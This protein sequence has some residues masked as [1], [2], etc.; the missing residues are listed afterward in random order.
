MKQHNN[1]V[2]KNPGFDIFQLVDVGLYLWMAYC[3]LKLWV[4]PTAEDVDRIYF[5]SIL[6]AF[7]FIMVHS[8]V[9]MAA[10]PLK[11]SLLLF[12]PVYGL[13]AFAFNLFVSDNSILYLYLGVVL[14][15]MRF[16]FFNKSKQ[17]TDQAIG[18][19]AYAVMVYFIP[20]IIVAIFSEKVPEFGVSPEFLEQAGYK[21][22]IGGIFTEM[23]QTALCLG[24][25]YYIL[26]AL[27]PIL[28]FVNSFKAWMKKI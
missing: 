9:F 27:L 6:I 2:G 18:F 24:A 19:S 5:M 25:C 22:K 28:M 11:W 3:F 12:F 23:P 13:F 17:A 14:F 20:M 4:M 21:I 15:R 16:A 10:M 7:E 26:L 8:G 1:K